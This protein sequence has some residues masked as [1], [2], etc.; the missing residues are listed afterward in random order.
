[1]KKDQIAT[2]AKQ[3]S[4]LALFVGSMPIHGANQ[5]AKKTDNPNILWLLCE[6]IT[7]LLPF[8]GDPTAHTPN[9][10]ALAK[11]SLVFTNCFTTSGV[12]GASRSALI[13]GM[14]P[15]SI[16][17]MN[18]RSGTDAVGWGDRKYP[19]INPD[20]PH[21]T[22]G[23]LLRSYS[24]V[25]PEY[26][27]CFTEYLRANG[28]FCTNNYKTDYNFAAPVT[29]WDKN[30]NEASWTSCPSGKP[31]FSVFSDLSTHESQI[32]IHKNFPQTVS[33]QKVPLPAYFPDDSIVRQDVARC[34]S[35]IEILDKNIGEKIKQLKDAGLYD[36]TIIFFF[37]DN[38]GPL[39]RGK[40]ESYDSGLHLPF[41]VHFPKGAHAG[42]VDE[43]ISFVDFAPTV[44]SVA[45]IK[46]PAYLQGQAFLGKYKAKEPRKYIYGGGDRFDEYSDRIRVVR[47]KRYLYVKNYF[48]ELPLYKDV[49][50]RKR[51][52]ILK[53]LLLLRDQNKLSGATALWFRPT[54]PNEEFYD[55]QTDPFNIHNLINDPRYTGKIKELRTSLDQWIA[56]VGDKGSIPESELIK[57]MWP[58]DAQPRTQQPKIIVNKGL[59]KLSCETLGSSIAYILSDKKMIPNLDSG[60]QLYSKPINPAKAKYLYVL[61]NRIGYADSEILEKEF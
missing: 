18:H 23:K 41:L 51:M 44:L 27:K 2:K 14:Y 47:D 57:Q 60:W 31:F 5:Q 46:P 45:G 43:L 20:K 21:D 52:D 53:E 38:G 30:S 36:N 33:P 24:A 13:T 58:N 42:R 40:R 48:P 11:E 37:S 19:D 56:K 55:C 34:Y 59:I 49:K 15:T 7:T 50:Y 17:T 28:Y 32:W 26:V 10:D 39:P 9:L 3:L 35:N 54:K 61:A 4:T 25:T 8:N 16:G 29:A 12:S 1:M 6:D 22:Q